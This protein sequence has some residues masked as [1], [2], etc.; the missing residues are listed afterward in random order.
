MMRLRFWTIVLLGVALAS[1]AFGATGGEERPGYRRFPLAVPSAGHA[2]LTLL[3]PETTG[4]FWTNFLPAARL[5]QRQNLINGAGV[6][7]GDFDGDGHCDIFLCNKDGASALFKNL[8]NWKFQDVAAMA[9][10]TCTNQSSTGATFADVNGDGRLDLLVNS[11]TGPNALFVNQG[12]GKFTNVTE[13][14]GLVSKGGT[15]SLA[16]GDLDGDGW[17]DLYVAYFGVESVLRDELKF[18]SRLVNGQPVVTGRFARRL[19]IIDGKLTEIG[20]PDMIYRNDGK[21]HFI[22]LKWEETFSDEN[23]KPVAPLWDFGLA[24]QIRDINGDGYPDIYVCND[25]QTPD[26]FWLNDGKGHFHPPSKWAM[27]SLSYNSMGVDFA[28]IDRDGRLDFFVVD[29]LP[30]DHTRYMTQ[31]TS[32]S[33][34]KHSPGQFEGMEDV[35]HNTLFWNRGDGTYAQVAFL[36]GLAASD[37]SWCPAFV[38]LDLDGFEDLLVSNGTVEAYADRDRDT[39]QKAEIREAPRFDTPNAAFRNL[40]NLRFED[41]TSTW[42]FG[43]T[44]ISQGMALADLDGDGDLDV[45]V[46][47]LNSPPLIYRNESSAPRIAI[48]LK[49]NSPNTQGVGALIKVLGAAVPQSQE[50]LAGG[51]YL[52]GDEAERVFACGAAKILSIEVKW[53]N[54]KRSV[55]TNAEPNF[56]YEIAEPSGESATPESAAPRSVEPLFSEASGRF[57]LPR[58]EEDFNDFKRQ[59]LLPRKLSQSGPGV[60][61]LDFPE[62]GPGILV[63][64]GKNQSPEI[65]FSNAKSSD[66]LNL[67]PATGEEFASLLYLPGVSGGE[68]LGTSSSYET[69]RTNGESVLRFGL[70][71]TNGGLK[72]EKLPG[73]PQEKSAVGPLAAVNLKGGKSLSLFVGGRVVPGRYPE[74]GRSRLYDLTDG[75]PELDEPNT[76]V[77]E[78][79]GM[80]S[81]AVF[82]DFDADGWPDLALA[83][84]WGSLR[85]YRNE[86][87]KLKDVTASRGMAGLTG[88][89]NSIAAGDFDGDGRMDLVAGNWGW[90]SRY[91][92]SAEKPLRLYYGDFNR[93]GGIDVVEAELIGTE[94]YPSR[95]WNAVGEALP[96]TREKVLTHRQFAK[97][98]VGDLLGE[99][100]ASAR[101]LEATELA[102]VVLLNRGDR[103][104]VHPLPVEAQVAPVFGISVADFDGDGHQDV[105]LAQNFFEPHGEMWRLDAGRGLILR[106][107]GKGGFT[108]MSGEE[109]GVKIYGEQR[110]SAVGDFDQDGRPDLVVG[111]NASTPVLLHNE[112]ARPG[113]R[114]RFPLDVQSVGAMVRVKGA[115]GWS[116]AVEARVGGG[117]LSQDSAELIFGVD[118]PAE[119]QVRWPGGLTMTN[120]IS[121]GLKSLLVDR[122]KI[123]SGGSPR[124]TRNGPNP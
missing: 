11:F 89:W 45:V 82:T 28:D 10:V 37:W 68:L 119:I 47:C 88:W 7:L 95:Q 32:L 66:R 44:N 60:A 122:A 23:G 24:V 76:R 1:R 123:E 91:Q 79:A 57:K 113:L 62:G 52:S 42:G 104:E 111:V 19:K 34:V 9:G 58:Q 30:R 87:G 78:S 69:G 63:G 8:G 33:P 90:N 61:W 71:V 101:F 29:M 40:G 80:V 6:A 118:R 26:R 20:E 54:G 67:S 84:D 39:S 51:R 115:N 85:F 106:G 27:R 65:L 4:I 102:S 22:P 83:C 103:F 112:K 110:G 86:N 38:D 75:R 72:I 77:I 105:F 46:N 55:I 96:F 99:R 97:T 108:G 17:L 74:S 117:Y 13:A 64:A 15:T 116:A 121:P 120:A 94:Y 107:D 12:G 53:R 98:S 48:R 36:S 2:G 41:V 18:S 109:S 35:G 16:L 14:A 81:G 93:S 50:I 124:A 43:S 73:V 5:M 92:A 100:F 25:F 114:V 49:G 56:R 70:V 59:P 21:G 31:A 3:P